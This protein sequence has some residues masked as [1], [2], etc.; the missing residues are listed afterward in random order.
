MG[1]LLFTMALSTTYP[2]TAAPR[3][4]LPDVLPR[5]SRP[6][7]G[8]MSVIPRFHRRYYG[9]FPLFFLQFSAVMT[10]R[11]D[12]QIR[13]LAPARHDLFGVVCGQANRGVTDEVFR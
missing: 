5:L 12:L 7:P 2:P 13:I 6:V 3:P 1:N 8:T 11:H 9:S 10:V 4:T